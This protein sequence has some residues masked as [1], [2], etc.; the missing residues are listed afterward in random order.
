MNRILTALVILSTCGLAQ[1]ADLII[2]QSNHTDYQIVVPDAVGDE[3]LQ[4]YVELGGKVL[5][6]AIRKAAGASAPL[7]REVDCVPGKPALFIGNTAAL[8]KA[9]LSSDA[10][11]PWEH[12]IAVRGQ[13]I[14]IYG[15]DLANPF[16]K[17][18]YPKYFIHYTNGTLKAACVFAEKF[19]NTRFVI[20]SHNAYGEHDGVRTLPQAQLSVPDHFSYSRKVRFRH[21]D[22]DKGGLLFSVANDYAFDCGAAY[23]V[24]YHAYAIPQDEYYPQ[25]PEY[26]ALRN[27]KRLYHRDPVH[28]AR[29][30]YC[31]SNPAVQE[32]IYQNALQRADDGY[33]VI[34]FGQSDGF[35]GCECA[36]CTAMYGVSDWGEK[37]WLLHRDLAVR[38]HQ[39]RPGVTTAIACYGP[40]HQLPQAFTKFSVPMI[41]D[42]APVT[43]ELLAGWQKFALLGMA[44]WTYYTGSYKACG[45]SPGI[46]FAEMK[47]EA[48]KM[49]ATPVTSLYNCGLKNVSSLNGPWYYAYGRLLENPA[50]DTDRLLADYCLFAFGEPAAPHFERFFRLLDA[51]MDQHRMS[52][53]EDYNDFSKKRQSAL[54]FWL[55]RYPPE[56]VAELGRHLT[57]GAELCEES[58]SLLPPLTAEFEYLSRTARVCHAIQ[59]M[60]DQPSDTTREKLADAVEARN[61]FIAALPARESDQRIT[62]GFQFAQKLHL[63]LGGSM[64]GIFGGAFNCD[65][66]ALRLKVPS[67]AA[68]RV[69]D[70][71]DPA[72]AQAPVV[73]VQAL[74]NS[75]PATEASFQLAYTDAALLLKML[76]PLPE[77]VEQTTVLPDGNL[78]N[79]AVWEVFVA[80]GAD[81]RQFVF[82]PLADSR[83]DACIQAGRHDA[84]WNTSWSQQSS[85]RNGKW[86]AELTIPFAACSR[87]PEAGER[88]AMQIAHSTPGA[89]SLYAW[90]IPLSGSFADLSGFGKV[91]FGDRPKG[92]TRAIDIDG[93]FSA[94]RSDG[95]LVHWVLRPNPQAL[96][97]VTAGT[98]TAVK[99]SYVP[100]SDYTG[101]YSIPSIPLETDE[102][103]VI[104]V[105]IRGA[106]NASLGLGWKDAGGKWVVNAGGE[107][108]ALS[109]QA[110]EY[111]TEIIRPEVFGA[112]RFYVTVFVAKDSIV[113]VESIAVSIK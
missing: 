29:P 2:A 56:V 72:W 49:R 101:L 9:G 77:P 10:F 25:H 108:Y 47:A 1:A 59:A 54:D 94:V 69:K 99:F 38:L 19:L 23:Q 14:Y 106:G 48:G 26:F 104:K 97:R 74:K 103:A 111:T 50:L 27:G 4:A 55:L 11:E 76:A 80:T 92:V 6:T 84:K 46:G 33:K 64:A 24:H 73:R 75:D 57:A 98:Q 105:R 102:T 81:I 110:Q 35:L 68:V 16:R 45:F 61:D 36:N 82:N 37:L 17:T 87:T 44:A 32:L 3:Q 22:G 34:E 95:S 86:Q 52:A 40:T 107:K 100:G 39:E 62:L 7:V 112:E 96:E 89:K 113:V 20:P 79:N 8:Q 21:C 71:A 85:I 78:W 28:G 13:D 65:P 63:R 41:I 5:Q 70:F 66:Q 91:K 109:D 51:R 42:C 31:L 60:H 12:A 30:Q 83:F 67:L 15:R 88:W 43:D 58:N 18:M 90:G 53:N 93:D